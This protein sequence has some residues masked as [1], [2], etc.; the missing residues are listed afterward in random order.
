M[1][2]QR[3]AV[4][5]RQFSLLPL[6]SPKPVVVTNPLTAPLAAAVE[7]RELSKKKEK[8]KKRWRISTI[9]K[10]RS[11]AKKKSR[12]K[13]I[14]ARVAAQAVGCTITTHGNAWL[15]RVLNP[16]PAQRQ[17]WQRN[18]ASDRTNRV[19][20]EMLSK[21]AS[22]NKL[23][24][25]KI[26]RAKHLV[27]IAVNEARVPNNALIAFE[28]RKKM[29][30]RA[31]ELKTTY[32]ARIIQRTFR[33]WLNA[34]WR[35]HF[36]HSDRGVVTTQS[37]KKRS[38]QSSIERTIVSILGPREEFPLFTRRIE[39]LDKSVHQKHV[40]RPLSPLLESAVDAITLEGRTELTAREQFGVLSLHHPELFKNSRNKAWAQR[41]CDRERPRSALAAITLPVNE[42]KERRAQSVRPRSP[43][44]RAT[45]AE[46]KS[47]DGFWKRSMGKERYERTRNIPRQK[48]VRPRRTVAESRAKSAPH[49]GRK[50]NIVPIIAKRQTRVEYTPTKR[51][52]KSKRRSTRQRPSTA[53]AR[54]SASFQ[55]N[56]RAQSERKRP[57]SSSS[58]GRRKRAPDDLHRKIAL[59]DTLKCRKLRVFKQKFY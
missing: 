48:N 46:L 24:P 19:Y 29:L 41:L 26:I 15:D 44:L 35:R 10:G 16:D 18:K 5:V 28:L 31:E 49:L 20:W 34:R 21:K 36:I 8:G 23:L 38:Q 47:V 3:R 40:L 43:V 13:S 11:K 7:D 50:K 37:F 27:D 9:R 39:S 53:V 52:S 12:S 45:D 57:A 51:T 32:A 2:R 33:D 59:A 55:Q 58:A 25:E 1:G 42:T 4:T 17:K 30:E 56:T 6:S 14:L 54:T 22:C